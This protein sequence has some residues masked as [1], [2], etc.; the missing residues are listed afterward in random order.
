MFVQDSSRVPDFFLKMT[1]DFSILFL[2]YLGT[3]S[4]L[5]FQVRKEDAMK[6]KSRKVSGKKKYEKPKLKKAGDLHMMITAT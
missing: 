1:V 6:K 5:M 2:Y 4:S 3:K